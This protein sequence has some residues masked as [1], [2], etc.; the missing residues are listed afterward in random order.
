MGMDT[1]ALQFAWLWITAGLLSGVV[2]GLGFHSDDWLGG[3]G[4]WRRRLVRL[5]HIAFFGTALLCIAFAVTV[6]R[7]EMAGAAAN[8]S[9]ALLIAGAIAMPAA[10]FLAAWRK[11]LRR[12]FVVP[13][14]CLVGGAGLFAAVALAAA[15]TGA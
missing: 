7:L 9:G 1:L 15:F 2:V 11:P 5:G 13:V 12:L 14:G 10:C 3:Y 8:W 6:P 4:S